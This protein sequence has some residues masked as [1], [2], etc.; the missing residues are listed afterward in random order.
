MLAVFS[1][2]NDGVAGYSVRCLSDTCPRHF[3]RAQELRQ[4]AR[5]FRLESSAASVSHRYYCFDILVAERILCH[6]RDNNVVMTN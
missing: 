4:G 1:L 3:S 5:Q 2:D 6:V